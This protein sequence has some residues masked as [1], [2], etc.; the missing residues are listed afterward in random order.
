SLI[1]RMPTRASSG[2]PTPT[3]CTT[4]GRSSLTT[5]RWDQT[6][7]AASTR[8]RAPP[9]HSSGTSRRSA[10]CS[11][12]GEPARSSPPSYGRRSTSSAASQRA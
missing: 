1:S 11:P 10:R 6:S 4:P 8:K 9:T 3:R 2:F 5:A 12:A 7:G